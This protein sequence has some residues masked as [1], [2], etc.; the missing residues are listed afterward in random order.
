MRNRMLAFIT[1][2]IIALAVPAYSFADDAADLLPEAELIHSEMV[3]AGYENGETAERIAEELLK[4]EE[5]ENNSSFTPK[6]ASSTTPAAKSINYTMTGNQAADI[7]GVAETQVGYESSGGNSVYGQWMGINGYAWC[8]AFVSWCANKAGISSDIVRYQT[9]ADRQWYKDTGTY[10]K[11]KY[12]GGSYTPKT[13]DLIFF[14]WNGNDYA[15]HIGVVSGTDKNY[16]YTIEGNSGSP[17]AVKKKYYGLS[18]KYVLGYACPKYLDQSPLK[19]TI[20][21]KSTFPADGV[22]K[23][24]IFKLTGTASSNYKVASVS[25]KLYG[26]TSTTDMASFSSGTVNAGSYDLSNMNR[27]IDIS[28]LPAGSYRLVITMKNCTAQNVA[29]QSTSATY[30]FKVVDK[31]IAAGKL[32][33]LKAPASISVSLSSY[34]S[35]RASWSKVNGAAGYYVYY[36]KNGWSSYKY[37]GR[38]TKLSY[39]KTGLENGAKYSFRVYPYLIS[40]GKRYKDSSRKTSSYIYTLKKISKPAVSGAS[41]SYIKISWNNI[42]G[43]SGYQIAKSKYSNK[44]FE[45]VKTVS[46]KYSSYKLKATKNKKYYYKVR[47]YRTVDGKKVCGPWSDARAYTLK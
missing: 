36:K 18:S 47:A 9:T 11:S 31:D 3:A 13:G 39:K 21:L 30:T 43:E 41:D 24:S 19:N 23:G 10:K 38:T 2:I 27:D 17:G 8:A 44:E 25:A 1:A 42:S 7:I 35:I 37:L 16:V 15:Q 4:A 5:A 12:R 6:A 40:N 32:P 29:S 22:A 33:D 20:S 28:T 26:G 34:N 46:S 45:V 14:T